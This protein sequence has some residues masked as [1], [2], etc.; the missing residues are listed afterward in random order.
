MHE[1][2]TV[3]FDREDGMHFE[4]IASWIG[5]GVVDGDSVIVIC[6]AAHRAVYCDRLVERAVD[7]QR[8]CSF[9]QLVFVDADEFLVSVLAD[10]VATREAFESV[11]QPLV[12]S[13]R[14]RRDRAGLR[15]YT[16]VRDGTGDAGRAVESHWLNLAQR[17]AFTLLIS[18]CR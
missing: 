10:G 2:E 4:T 8:A 1:I 11:V 18:E 16:E 5:R 13:A 3:R 12:D 9:G 15:V 7:V 6:S 14:A 17:E